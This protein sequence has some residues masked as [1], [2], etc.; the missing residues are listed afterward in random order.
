MNRYAALFSRSRATRPRLGFAIAVLVSISLSV[1]GCG[2]S[3]GSS[4]PSTNPDPVPTPTPAPTP[5]PTPLQ[6]LACTMTAPTVDCSARS[7][8]QPDL[9]NDLQDAVDAAVRTGGVMY[10][11][12]PNVIYDLDKFRGIVIATLAAKGMCGAW[13]WGNEQADEIFVRSADGCVIEQYDLLTGDGGIR[14]AGKGSMRWQ[15]GWGG[16]SVPGP[17]PNFSKEGDTS[18]SLSGDRTTFVVSIKNTSGEYGREMYDM[19]MQVLDENPTLFDKN[20]YLGGQ[21]SANPDLLRLPSWRIQNV[22]TYI[23]KIEAKLRAN[24][25]CGYIEKGD[26]LKIKK[27]S[28][29][30]IFHE[31]MDVV[32]NP[33]DGG[34]FVSY[35]IKDR[36]HNAGF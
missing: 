12:R 26:I 10:A 33:A 16:A 25:F 20:D 34:S 19:M 15:V 31:E 35:V 22:D 1:P 36:C 3:S 18:C 29:G 14:P 6:P 28:R 24:G 4:G 13:D 23:A 8:K 21:G 30:N 11:D 5:T 27:V 7:T 17:K 2:G 9:A 32:Q